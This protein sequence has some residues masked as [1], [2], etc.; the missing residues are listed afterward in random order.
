[1]PGSTPG[2]MAA[3]TTFLFLLSGF[4]TLSLSAHFKVL[5]FEQQ[6]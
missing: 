6:N 1:M 3:A 4:R 5:E 2:K